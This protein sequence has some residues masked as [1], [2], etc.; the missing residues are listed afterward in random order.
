MIALRTSGKEETQGL[1]RRLAPKLITGDVIFLKGGLGAGKSTFAR[2][3]I[4]A[5]TREDEEAPSPTF[6]LVQT[7]AARDFDIWHFDLY[8]LKRADEAYELGLEE[9]LD[10]GVA[11]IEWPERLGNAVPN[12]RLDIELVPEPSAQSGADAEDEPRLV[13]LTGYG[14]RGEA[15][16]QEFR[17]A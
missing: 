13:R 8:R 3:L 5:L 16:E 6:T 1:A 15:L 9:A 10:E 12:S 11:L 2:A 17:Q 4:R 14:K 7:Y